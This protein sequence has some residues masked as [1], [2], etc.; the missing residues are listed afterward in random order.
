MPDK[1]VDASILGAIIFEE[2]RADEASALVEGFDLQAPTL[3][4][5][6]LLHIAQKKCLRY[7]IQREAFQEALI[8]AL[9]MAIRW[10]EVD[11]IAVLDLALETGLSTYDASY[12]YLARA[13]GAPLATFD[14]R[15]AQAAGEPT[16]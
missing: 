3:V 8:A 7:P 11:Y 15:L 13:L 6:E 10:H 4:A 9:A 12:L 2:P 16:G 14:H 1:V 5:Y